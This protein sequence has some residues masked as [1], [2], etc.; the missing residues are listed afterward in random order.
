MST[1]HQQ[2]LHHLP[3]ADPSV[4]VAS[5]TTSLDALLNIRPTDNGVMFSSI[6]YCDWST[7]PVDQYM[8]KTTELLSPIL[9]SL[10]VIVISVVSV[11]PLTAPQ[12]ETGTLSVKLNVSSHSIISSSMM[13]IVNDVDISS[14]VTLTVTDVII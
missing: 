11:A 1:L 2:L 4:M 7:A 8:I 6:E 9:P 3:L 12:V 10:S 5:T 14:A 13:F